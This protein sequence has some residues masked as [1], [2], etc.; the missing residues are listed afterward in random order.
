MVDLID[1][2]LKNG[3][4][5]VHCLAG[6]QRSAAVIA[7]YL[8]KFHGKSVNESID[9]VKSKKR[10]AFF[11]HVNFMDTISRNVYFHVN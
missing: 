7:S 10:D 8:I 6:R 3:I 11:P 1:N 4:V 5:V 2:H 9:F